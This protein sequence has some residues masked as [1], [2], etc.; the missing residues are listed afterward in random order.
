[1]RKIRSI[2]TLVEASKR[3]G[4][5]LHQ[6]ADPDAL[7]SG[8][9][10]SSLLKKLNRKI[11]VDLIA[12]EGVSRV[13][14]QVLSCIR[15]RLREPRNF[16]GYDVLFTV[17]TNTTSQLG[18][19]QT[20]LEEFD[21]PVVVI[22]HH[23]PDPKTMLIASHI[24]SNEK[25]SSTAQIIYK[26]YQELQLRPRRSVAFS[27]F[28][29]LAYDT[30][31]FALATS[32]VFKVASELVARGVDARKAMALLQVP[33]TESE[34]MA[35][36]KGAQRLLIKQVGGW[37]LAAS[38]VGSHQASAARSLTMLGA[39]VAI[40]AGEK[41]NQVRVS[42][43]STQDFYDKTGIHLGRDV[44]RPV[45]ELIEG[46]GGGHAL[47]SGICGRGEAKTALEQCLNAIVGRLENR[48]RANA[49]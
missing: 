29:G 18:R 4:I 30:R 11:L 2:L 16:T 19:Y 12:P 34:K 24:F 6:N 1:M 40:V 41:K 25:A 13:S 10:L 39:D 45:G 3:A 42:L 23:N 44:A 14:R 38:R 37:I 49:T 32:E 46:A 28:L 20:L 48:A 21:G 47:S 26:F 27:L 43:R 22:D 31:H 8:Y 5:L 36:L 7:C 9:A 15:M 35:R 33:M 17:D